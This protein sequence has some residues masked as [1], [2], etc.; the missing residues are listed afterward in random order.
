MAIDDP[1]RP[2]S[3]RLCEC[4]QLVPLWPELASTPMDAILADLGKVATAGM[5]SSISVSSVLMRRSIILAIME[6]SS[7][8]ARTPAA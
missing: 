3:R 1:S 4:N 2:S 8:F 6:Y 5:L 7:S